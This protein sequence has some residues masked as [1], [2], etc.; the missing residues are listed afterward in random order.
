VDGAARKALEGMGIS[1]TVIAPIA[2]LSPPGAAAL[3]ASGVGAAPAAAAGTTAGEEVGAGTTVETIPPMAFVPWT[4][5]GVAAAP[6]EDDD[7]VAVTVEDDD[8]VATD[9]VFDA[10]ETE[11][12]EVVV[13]AADAAESV[14]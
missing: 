5:A 12:A 2:L 4:A 1:V 10:P 7:D 13:S 14:D 11:L 9:E 8:V 3:T 6:V